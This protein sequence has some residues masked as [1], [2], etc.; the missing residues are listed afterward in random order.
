MSGTLKERLPGSCAVAF[1]EWEG[2]C[3]ALERGLQSIILRKG[4]IAEGPGGFVPEHPMFWLYPTR[5][6]QAQQ[7]L[8]IEGLSLGTHD[9]ADEATVELRSLAVV[10]LIG[11]IDHPELLPALE[12]LH[13]WTAETVEKRFEYRHAGLWV[14]GVRVYR[15]PDA[16]SVE[17]TPEHAGC[18]TWVPLDRP[19]PTLGV[20]PVID[21][22]VFRETLDR[23]KSCLDRNVAPRHP[24]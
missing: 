5:I 24:A 13:V 1:K 15:R 12:P 21:D 14:L 18:K 7:G 9:A 11:R 23:L 20:E 3:A 10:E 19:L 22:E 16:F 4:G 6:H 2:V 17:V 8:R